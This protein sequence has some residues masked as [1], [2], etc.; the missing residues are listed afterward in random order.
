VDEVVDFHHPDLHLLLADFLMD[1]N[2]Q[3]QRMVAY[4]SMILVEWLIYMLFHHYQLD[5]LHER[6]KLLDHPDVK[7]EFVM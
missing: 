7:Q 6:Y 3:H 2:V 5:L 1:E 4:Q